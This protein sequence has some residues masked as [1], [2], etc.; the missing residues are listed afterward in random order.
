MNNP[1]SIK[2]KIWML[3]AVISVSGCMTITNARKV[4]DRYAGLGRDDGQLQETNH[5]DL[6][7]YS[8][9][10]LVDFA[11]TNRPSVVR[12]ALAVEDARLALKQLRADA[13]LISETP[14]LSPKLSVNGGYS[15]SSDSAYFNDL[16]WN[17]EGG[18][19]AAVNLSIPIFD[20]GR[21]N[22]RVKSQCE[23]VLD[24]ELMLV[25]TGYE[26]FFEVCDSYFG[27]LEARALYA[28]ALTNELEFSLHLEQAQKRS[29]AGEADPL[30]VLRAQ[31]DLAQAREHVVAAQTEVDTSGAEFLKALGIDASYGTCQDVIRFDGDPL[32]F[33][34]RGFP[35]TDYTVREAFDL[36][37]TNAPTMR[38]MRSRLRAAASDVDYAIADLMPEISAS[39]SLDWTD[40]L[41]YWHWGV[42]AAQSLF[43]GF[44]KTTAVDRAVIALRQA[45]QDVESQELEISIALENAVAQRDTALKAQETAEASL[46]SARNNLDMVREQYQL[47]EVDRV[48]FTDS[49]A[50]YVSA[51]GNRITAFY[52]KQRAECAVFALLG[53]YPVYEEKKITEEEK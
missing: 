12:S 13:P 35:D 39:V 53:V 28:V 24:S 23:A 51:L 49:V 38:V 37:R 42:S 52:A 22:A 17:T 11:M 16:S 7:G 8:L 5:I 47:G 25:E 19:A 31:L 6:S 10:S 9:S 36:A 41:W 44:R 32:A 40:P 26:V 14:W 20:F 21:H 4:Q 34:M 2:S 29:D 43:L 30:D 27:L 45:A 1:M 15:A 18:A 33:V 46:L 48:E 3:A 50:A